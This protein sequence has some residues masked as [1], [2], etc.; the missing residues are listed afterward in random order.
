MINHSGLPR[1]IFFLS[2]Q[3]QPSVFCHLSWES[4]ADWE[5]LLESVGSS[6]SSSFLQSLFNAVLLGSHWMLLSVSV[7]A[8]LSALAYLRH[9]DLRP[10]TDW[11]K[12]GILE[13]SLLLTLHSSEKALIPAIIKR[14][15]N[16]INAVNTYIV[17]C[18]QFFVISFHHFYLI[19]I[20]VSAMFVLVETAPPESEL[21]ASIR[22]Q[23][24]QL[25]FLSERGNKPKLAPCVLSWPEW[26][27]GWV[28]LTHWW[29]VALIHPY[30]VTSRS[31]HRQSR[32]GVWRGESRISETGQINKPV[33]R[34]MA[35]WPPLSHLFSY[36][37][38]C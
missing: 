16:N 15:L 3:L 21:G 38:H 20:L 10:H 4:H 7:Q 34:S 24:S 31:G 2:P 28:V 8:G 23:I 1:N 26:W 32:R 11:R 37:L 12:E 27:V 9:K 29:K 19:C 18:Q 6:L 22:V 17:T 36:L 30:M 14:N 13:F 33:S 35:L 5:N 25:L